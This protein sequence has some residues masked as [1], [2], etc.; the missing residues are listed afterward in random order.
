MK[1]FILVAVSFGIIPVLNKTKISH[2]VKIAITALVISVLNGLAPNIIFDNFLRIFKNRASVEVLLVVGIVGI[3]NALMSKYGLLEKIVSDL[4]AIIK[5]IRILFILMPALIGLLAVPGGAAMSAP[6]VM[7]LGEQINMPKT[8]RAAVNL[9]FRHTGLFLLPYA[10][11]NLLVQAFFPEINIYKFIGVNSMFLSAMCVFSYFIY[12]SD[13][14]VEKSAV[15]V[16]RKEVWTK[17]RSL[18]VNLSP[19]YAG[20]VINMLLGFRFSV[21]LTASIAILYFIGPRKRFVGLLFK[22]IDLNLVLSIVAIFFVQ[23]TILS[24]EEL[25][26]LFSAM[27]YSG[28]YSFFAIS[29]AAL[30]LGIITGLALPPLGV[31]LPL[32]AS[33]GLNENAILPYVYLVFCSAFCGYFFSPLHMCQVLTNNYIGVKTDELWKEYKQLFPLLIVFLGVSFFVFRLIFV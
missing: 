5:S 18:A 3:I 24:L 4:S 22:S 29:F 15:P 14:P 12:L 17:I 16:P 30:F 11:C 19:I 21:C 33:L 27:F 23:E 26:R 1:Q 28:A 25:S 8:R 13:I 6:L 31:F 20:V 10:S 2:G 32:V 7:G 9:V